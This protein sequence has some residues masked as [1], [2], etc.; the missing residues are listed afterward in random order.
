MG[1]L[2]RTD[3][4]LL[5][6]SGFLKWEIDEINKGYVNTSS[7]VF[8]GMVKSRVM[9]R[10]SMLGAG[11]TEAQINARVRHWYRAK[12][13]RSPFDWLKVEYRATNKLT[14]K[15]LAKQLSLRRQISRTF[16]HSYGRIRSQKVMRKIGYRGIPRPR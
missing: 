2:T 3:V 1:S 15:Q 7:S 11:W 9:W 8:R 5:K 16:G 6:D 10:D 14:I 12:N 4:K 13:D